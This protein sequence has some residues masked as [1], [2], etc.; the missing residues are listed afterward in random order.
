MNYYALA[1]LGLVPLLNKF[2]LQNKL[3]NIVIISKNETLEI[4]IHQKDKIKDL[5]N[6]LKNFYNLEVNDKLFFNEIKL[7][8]NNTILS[9]DID[10]G[11][12]L[13]FVTRELHNH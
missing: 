4:K 1:I 2:N 10:E 7:E 3:I 11:S 8:D 6:M 5:K 13:Y 9:Y 12:K